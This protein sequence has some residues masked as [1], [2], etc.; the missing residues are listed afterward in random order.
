MAGAK[1]LYVAIDDRKEDLKDVFAMMA[2]VA[3]RQC[4][5]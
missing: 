2:T 4:G 1:H 5:S 3:L